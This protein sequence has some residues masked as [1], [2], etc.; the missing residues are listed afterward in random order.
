VTGPDTPPH[1][2]AAADALAALV[3]DARRLA[4]SAV[5]DAALALL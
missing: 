1:L 5:V 3:P 4:D 2:A